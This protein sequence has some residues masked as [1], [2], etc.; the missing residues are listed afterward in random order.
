MQGCAPWI[1]CP[2]VGTLWWVGARL[3][4]T[5]PTMNSNRQ[6]DCRQAA[7]E[8]A[9]IPVLLTSIME[10]PSFRAGSLYRPRKKNHWVSWHLFWWWN[11]CRAKWAFLR[12]SSIH[13]KVT[14]LFKL[15]RRFTVTGW[16]IWPTLP[17]F[18]HTRHWT[19][20]RVWCAVPSLHKWTTRNSHMN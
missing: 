20:H 9:Q 7:K 15:T 3:P 14:Y 4:K 11:I 1:L 8:A 19:L 5:S 17:V 10:N 12:L 13:N 2:Y 6:A 16:G 18:H